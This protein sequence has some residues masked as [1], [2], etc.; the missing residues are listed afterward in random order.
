VPK[1]AIADVPGLRTWLNAT[2]DRAGLAAVR[3]DPAR[4]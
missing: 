4:S 1:R 2:A 3:V